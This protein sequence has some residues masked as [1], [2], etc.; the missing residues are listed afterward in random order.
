[1]KEFKRSLEHTTKSLQMQ[2]YNHIV[3]L[4]LR[5]YMNIIRDKINY[6]YSDSRN[7]TQNHD[8]I[9]ETSIDR[10]KNMF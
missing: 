3:C 6:D 4:N 10:Y 1:M 7:L 9:S 2:T 5:M 8:Q